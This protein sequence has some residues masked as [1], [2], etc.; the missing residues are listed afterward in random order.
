MDDMQ[1]ISGNTEEEIWQQIEAGLTDETLSYEALVKQNG[2]EVTIYMDI[3]PGG[4]FEGGSEITQL[5]SALS[6]T[7]DFKFSIHDSH[8]GDSI[9]KFFGM[10]DVVLGF[11]DFD[12]HLIVKT[13]DEYRTHRI[14][15]DA[16]VRSVFV[17]MQSFDCG[18]HFHHTEETDKQAF[19]EL[20]IN[21]GINDPVTLR[22]IYL[23]FYTLML[24]IEVKEFTT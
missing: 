17:L 16:N 15:D 1:V 14:F 22:K 20:N 21:Q 7:G 24:R 11:P 4:G 18:I 8:F 12:E 19:L 10:Q 9:G 6:V 3:D 23:A 13:D 5:K 2:K